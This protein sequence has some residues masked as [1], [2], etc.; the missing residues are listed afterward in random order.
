[1]K[2]RSFKKQCGQTNLSALGD[3]LGVVEAARKEQ[4]FDS[5][6]I[7][8]KCAEASETPT[9]VTNLAC[10]S[11]HLLSE[12]RPCHLLRSSDP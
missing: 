6:V 5:K 1:M 4:W 2:S 10:L 8:S 7:L 3:F 11:C 9:V 12:V